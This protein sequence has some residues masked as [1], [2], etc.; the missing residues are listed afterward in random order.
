MPRNSVLRAIERLQGDN[1][2]VPSPHVLVSFARMYS[3]SVPAVARRLVQD[4]DVWD[5]VV[6]CSAWLPRRG[7]KRQVGSEAWRAVWGYA[8]TRYKDNLFLPPFRELP[9]IRLQAAEQAFEQMLQHK[10]LLPEPYVEPISRFSL[11]NLAKFL[12]G[13]TSEGNTRP[14]YTTCYIRRLTLFDNSDVPL[15]RSREDMRQ[16]CRIL[17]C[18]PLS[19]MPTPHG[20]RATCV[21]QI[22]NRRSQE[23]EHDFC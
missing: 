23:G 11:G 18:I 22:S 17:L 9:R 7:D 12:R 14:V 16:Q 13:M 19:K 6:L 2:A 15:P 4:L 5:A 20:T 21:S 1:P 8:P 10:S 3:V